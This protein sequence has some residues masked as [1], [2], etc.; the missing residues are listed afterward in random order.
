MSSS[1]RPW[2]QSRFGF[3]PLFLVP[4]GWQGKFTPGHPLPKGTELRGDP[5]MEKPTTDLSRVWP[6]WKNQAVLKLPQRT[7]GYLCYRFAG[8]R[9][10]RIRVHDIAMTEFHAFKV[11]LSKQATDIAFVDENGH[12]IMIDGEKVALEVVEPCVAVNDPRYEHLPTY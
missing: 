1:S 2:L 9:E 10:W 3:A 11:N 8:Q 4:I 5:E 7:A 12:E 6:T